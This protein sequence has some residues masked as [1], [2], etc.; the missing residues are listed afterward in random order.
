MKSSR[1]QSATSLPRAPRDDASARMTKY[2]TMMVIR[3]ICFVLMVAV[4]PYSWYTWL[5]GAG[6]MFLPYFAV[7]IANVASGSAERAVAPER[8][9]EAT[10]TVRAP[11]PD[12]TAA[13]DEAP[14][15][16]R[17]SESS[18]QPPAPRTPSDDT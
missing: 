13:V 11:S 6:A 15:V 18:H 16:I 12:P 7:V 3:V 9:I 4:T 17:L 5:F 14:R 8:A 1:P 10:P 2:F